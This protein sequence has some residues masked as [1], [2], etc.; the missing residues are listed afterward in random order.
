MSTS[1]ARLLTESVSERMTDLHTGS[2]YR[3]T[4]LAEI[5]LCVAPQFRD[6][7]IAVSCRI[8]HLNVAVA[9]G[10]FVPVI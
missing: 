2:P 6:L 5:K 1:C 8:T 7:W 4:V 10:G 9:R 3:G